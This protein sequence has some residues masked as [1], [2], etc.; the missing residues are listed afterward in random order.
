MAFIEPVFENR[1]K[2]SKLKL[3]AD[4]IVKQLI[5]WHRNIKMHEAKQCMC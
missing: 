4:Y 2:K 3:L 5:I 1:I